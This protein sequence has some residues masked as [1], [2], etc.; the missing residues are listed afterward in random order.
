MSL[1]SSWACDCLLC[2]FI[3]LHC[4]IKVQLAVAARR[5][6]RGLTVYGI[7]DNLKEFVLAVR[8]RMN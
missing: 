3:V 2:F 4:G 7:E 1:V 8:E 6:R 5:K